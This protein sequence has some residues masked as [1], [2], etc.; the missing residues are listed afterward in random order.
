MRPFYWNDSKESFTQSEVRALLTQQHDYFVNETDG[1][2]Q[3]ELTKLASEKESLSTE[4]QTLKDSVQLLTDEK[5]E[6]STQVDGFKERLAPIEKEAKANTAKELLEGKVLGGAEVDAYE[7]LN[8]EGYEEA[9]NKEEFLSGKLEELFTSKPY[10]KV[11]VE[12]EVKPTPPNDEVI[13]TPEGGDDE[14]H[15]AEGIGWGFNR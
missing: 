9:E 7:L 10:L 8:L 3:E 5:K 14:T 4:N 12:E 2:V 6:L 1:K 15:T 13:I 11:V